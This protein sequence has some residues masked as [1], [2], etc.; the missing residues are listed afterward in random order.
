MIIVKDSVEIERT[1]HKAEGHGK[2]EHQEPLLTVKVPS[3]A[4]CYD[5][6][7]HELLDTD[8]DI[9][10]GV[11][12]SRDEKE[13]TWCR[14]SWPLPKITLFVEAVKAAVELSAP[15]IREDP[16]LTA[17]ARID[18][19]T[20]VSCMFESEKVAGGLLSKT[21]YEFFQKVEFA[22][23]VSRTD[24]TPYTLSTGY[25]RWEPEMLLPLIEI[26]EEIVKQRNQF[27]QLMVER[28]SA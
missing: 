3:Q 18:E 16:A 6:T 5:P 17:M 4:L 8:I 11:W 7:S 24:G 14:K 20:H 21:V 10:F 25:V 22:F 2:K 23:K 1:V 13:P 27:K 12:H 9:R 26:Q 28:E 19:T 15:Y